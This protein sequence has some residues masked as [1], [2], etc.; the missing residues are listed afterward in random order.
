MKKKRKKKEKQ[1]AKTNGELGE[2]PQFFIV[3]KKST[4]QVDGV[5]SQ[6]RQKEHKLGIQLIEM[7]M[8]HNKADI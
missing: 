6:W 8:V 4:E 3:H 5:Q 7:D 1:K 2:N